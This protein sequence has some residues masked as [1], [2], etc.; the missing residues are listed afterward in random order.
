MS[1]Q[2]TLEPEAVAADRPDTNFLSPIWERIPEG[3]P[4]LL[5]GNGSLGSAIRFALDRMN[6]P[7]VGVDPDKW[8]ERNNA[9][10]FAGPVG[11]QKAEYMCTIEDAILSETLGRTDF[12]LVITATD[13][14]ESRRRAFQYFRP[15]AGF[16]DVR[17][18]RETGTLVSSLLGDYME[19][20]LPQ[21][22]EDPGDNLSCAERGSMGHTMAISGLGV[23][24]AIFMLD[25]LVS[26]RLPHHNFSQF[27]FRGSQ[28]VLVDSSKSL[29][30]PKS[31][32]YQSI[33]L[34][35]LETQGTRFLEGGILAM[36][37]DHLESNYNWNEEYE[38]QL[39]RLVVMGGLEFYITHNND[40][41][42]LTDEE[43]E[44]I[45]YLN[46]SIVPNVSLVDMDFIALVQKYYKPEDHGLRLALGIPCEEDAEL[47]WRRG[48]A[49][50]VSPEY[51]VSHEGYPGLMPSNYSIAL[52]R[53]AAKQREARVS[54][55]VEEEQEA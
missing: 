38:D 25:C 43:G 9:N 1:E 17:A 55:A 24:R 26:G 46:S 11:E 23:S 49:G 50:N 21:G 13:N 37:Y 14:V 34:D 53:E 30:Q 3:R 41:W 15:I 36:Y 12:S 20:A 2:E 18:G 4:V 31:F 32:Q 48:F 40:G 22:I 7:S 42:L 19:R 52:S 45:R 8:E 44:G 27:G 29:P 54:E 28:V 33:F 51:L 39:C 6:I 5:V 10:S 16:V 35:A 47:G